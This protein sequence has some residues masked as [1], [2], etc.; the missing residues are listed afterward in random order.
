M[1]ELLGDGVV[2]DLLNHGVGQMQAE[3][4]F[5]HRLA[6]G[7]THEAQHQP[8]QEAA[9]DPGFGHGAGHHRR[10]VHHGEELLCR[11]QP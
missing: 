10:L 9:G 3:G 8:E 11:H 5:G 2:D 6:T 1:D 4:E 7:G